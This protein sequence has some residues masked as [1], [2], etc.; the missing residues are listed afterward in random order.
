MT[1]LV[2]D[3]RYSVRQLRRSPGFTAVAVLTLA[4]GIGASTTMFGVMDAVLLRPLPFRD[5]DRLVRIFSTRGDTL[6]G[7]SSL[8]VRDFATQNHTFENLAAY[9]SGWRKNI[10]MPGTSVEAEQM[11]VGLVSAAYFE[12][13]GIKPLMG[14][15]FTEQENQWGNNFEVII[16]YEF[17]QTRFQGNP[18]VLGKTIR[19]NDEPYT[20]IGVIPAG[21]PDWSFDSTH[22]R[23]E[24][25]TPFVPFL[26]ASDTV[27]DEAARGVRGAWAIGRLKAGVS[28]DQARADLQRIAS[29]LSARYPLDH[30]VGVTVRRLQEDRVAGL[31]PTL[32]LLMGAV[33]LIL[34]IACSNVANLLLVRNSGRTRELALK[35]ALGAQKAALIRQFLTENLVLGFGG[36]IVGCAL[37]WWG[38][39]VVARVHPAELRQLGA[40]GVDTRVL[41]FGIAISVLSSLV[42]G[43]LPAWLGLKVNPAEA[44]KAGGRSNTGSKTR[45]HL[46]RLF[47][48]S[49]MAFAVMLLIGT[50]LLTRSLMRLQDQ[51]PGFRVDHLLRE[52]LFLPPVRY[53]TPTLITGFCDDYAARIRALPGVRDATFSAAYVPGEDWR[54]DFIIEGRAISRLEETPSA[55]FN[56]TDSHY[57]QTLG[58][59]LISGR[60]FSDFDTETSVPVALVNQAFVKA[61]FPDEDPIGKQLQLQLSQSTA[62]V[63]NL[64]FTIIGVTGD[65]L[66]PGLALPPVPQITTLFRQ[67]PDLNYGF[68]NLIVRTALDPLQLTEPIR[69]QLHSLDPNLPFAEVSTMGELINGET[70]NRRYTTGLLALFALFG[71]VLA[72]IGVYGVVSYVVAQRTHEIGVRMALGAQGADVL[73]LILKYGLGMAIAGAGA[74]LFGAWMLRQVVAQMVFGISPADP[75]TFSAVAVVAIGFATAASLVPARRATK[76]DPMVALRYE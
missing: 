74:G 43:S 15:L 72:L 6:I 14:R 36:G 18:S 68:K 51:R 50:G 56:V 66:N 48:A 52:H 33:I 55:N 71:V 8:D 34:L 39:A 47:V 37:A 7:P 11:P 76:V 32:R 22:G 29:N 65:A 54:Q 73:W 69:R 21:L 75:T 12:V 19:I 35:A 17:W 63:G 1:G 42:F 38:C 26:T 5:P 64:R 31:R 41:V 49:E 4:L 24:L 67:T 2:Q 30:G 70:A 9:D 28:L 13:L 58:I 44:L 40:V 62:P 10:S 61:F 46:G 20:V 45:N 59:P 27:W 57:V 23:V 60:N 25:W 3:I 53:S 16:S